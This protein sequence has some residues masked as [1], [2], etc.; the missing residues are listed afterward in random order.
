MAD[1]TKEKT[2]TPE[3]R[4][5]MFVDQAKDYKE[6]VKSRSMSVDTEL[7][8]YAKEMD[9]INAAV[10]VLMYNNAAFRA[11]YN[12]L[13]ASEGPRA[14]VSYDVT[15]KVGNDSG[16]FDDV[17]KFER[18]APLDTA[19]NPGGANIIQTSLADTILYK[20]EK[21]G[22]ILAAVAKD[23]VSYGDKEYPKM[24]A[25]AVGEFIDENTTGFTDIVPNSYEV[26]TNGLTKVKFTPRDYGILA[27]YS[28][29]LLRKVTP[30]T[31]K[32]FRDYEANALT[33][34]I[35]QQILRGDGTGQNATGITGI[36]T[37][38]TFNGNAYLTFCDAVGILGA[39]DTD[40]IQAVMHRKTWQEFKKLRVVNAAYRDSIDPKAMKIDDIP[41]II[42]NNADASVATQGSIILGDMSH[43]MYVAQSGIETIED[44]YTNAATR[45]VN[46]Y[47]TMSID[48]GA[49]IASSF[50]TFP[51]TF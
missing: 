25:K 44:K 7:E 13:V 40:N 18:A 49:L 31:I 28:Q 43:Y 32:F 8:F 5:R 29:R 33:R 30:A 23:Q 2:Y 24:S 26:A 35:E 45:K 48:L 20:M 19:S 47:H 21:I 3:Q 37:A 50:A 41:V 36:A 34:G 38:V 10:D 6:H 46:M 4:M 1:A 16:Y 14:Q 9:S 39:A 11:K 27:S 17:K 15:A 12:T 42:S 22:Q 51:I